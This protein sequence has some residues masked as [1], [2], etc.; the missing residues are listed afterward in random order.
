MAFVIPIKRKVAR[1]ADIAVVKEHL[2][3]AVNFAL[4]STQ[5]LK[6]VGVEVRKINEG[7]VGSVNV[8]GRVSEEYLK[9]FK[10]VLTTV[11]TERF[12]P[13]WVL[14]EDALPPNEV[15]AAGGN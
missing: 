3:K 1:R 7:F 14:T 4:K 11:F 8:D 9:A 10:S 15:P 6:L 2:V 12:A 13:P 5:H